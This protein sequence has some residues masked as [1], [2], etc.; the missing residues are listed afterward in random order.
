MLNRWI[1][2]GL[3]DALEETGAGCIV[4]SPLAQG[5]LTDR[6][7]DGV[8]PDSRGAHHGTMAP[9]FLNEENIARARA[10]NDIAKRRG[11]TLAQ[12]AI[13]WVLRDPRVTSALIG[14][15]SVRQLETNV[16]ALANLD[17]SA[18]ELAEIDRYAVDAGINLWEPSSLA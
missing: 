18:D 6:Y 13:A 5:L 1:E 11:Q 7:L 9:E 14:A 12:L 4:F 15:S 3:L 17:L 16:G 10:L 2:G 8:P